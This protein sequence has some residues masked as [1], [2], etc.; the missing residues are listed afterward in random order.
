[1]RQEK[2]SKIRTAAVPQRWGVDVLTMPI[3]LDNHATTRTDPRVVEAMLPYFS[4]IYG[5]AASVSHRFGWDAEDAVDRPASRSPR[6][7]GPSREIVF[8]SG[9]T[10]ANN[11]A[12]KGAARLCERKGN[13]LVTAASEHRAVLDTVKAAGTRRLGRHRSCLATP[14]A[15]VVRRGRGRRH[16]RPDRPGLGHGGQQRG[17][18][19]QPDS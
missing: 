3:Y 1:M 14:P 7:S 2:I 13:H 12:I 8:T 16:H 18:H 9:A 15:R 10:E 6:R 5:N 4:E 17:R 19:A 11:L